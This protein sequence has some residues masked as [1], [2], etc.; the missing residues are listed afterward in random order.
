NMKKDELVIQDKLD[1][2]NVTPEVKEGEILTS[3]TNDIFSLMNYGNHDVEQR[4]VLSD[5]VI[6]SEEAT[7]HIA[8]VMTEIR[9]IKHAMKGNSQEIVC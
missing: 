4:T 8:K 6:N 3:K 2:S 5:Q 7:C 1:D 9:R